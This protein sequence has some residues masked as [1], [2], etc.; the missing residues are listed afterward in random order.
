MT[1]GRVTKKLEEYISESITIFSS[2]DITFMRE[3]LLL[4]EIR[5][6]RGVLS[7]CIEKTGEK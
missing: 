3:L 5:T 6:D 7:A 1:G 4:S 2:M